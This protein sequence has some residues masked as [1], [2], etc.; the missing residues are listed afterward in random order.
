[1]LTEEKILNFSFKILPVN[2]MENFRY[3]GNTQVMIFSGKTKWFFF[4]SEEQLRSYGYSCNWLI[5]S[6]GAEYFKAL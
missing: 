2:V 1:M 5:Q 3:S 4:P 6:F